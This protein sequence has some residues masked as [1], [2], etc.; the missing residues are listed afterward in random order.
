MKSSNKSTTSSNLYQPRVLLTVWQKKFLQK[1]TKTVYPL[2][3]K[4]VFIN[5]EEAT[6]FFPIY[7]NDLIKK[8]LLD[9]DLVFTSDNKINEDYIQT[10]LVTLTITRLEL[11]T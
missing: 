4:E 3:A 8:G 10:C 7:I 5:E 1:P 11:E 2:D 9:K 6:D